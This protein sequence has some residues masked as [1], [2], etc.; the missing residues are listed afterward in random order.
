MENEKG[1]SMVDRLLKGTWDRPIMEHL[2]GRGLAIIAI[3]FV[4]TTLYFASKKGG[5]YE[6]EH[7]KGNGTAH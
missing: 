6:S 4:I 7:Y 2:L 5:Y 3:P 1:S